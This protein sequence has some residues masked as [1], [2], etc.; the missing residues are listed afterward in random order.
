VDGLSG[1]SVTFIVDADAP[2]GI[3]SAAILEMKT[4]KGA[5]DG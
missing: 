5:S 1:Q 3:A 2:P 4:A